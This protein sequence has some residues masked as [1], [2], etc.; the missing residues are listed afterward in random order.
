MNLGNFRTEIAAKLS[1]NVD[2]VDELAL[3]DGWVNDGVCYIV[4]EG[5]TRVTS[6]TAALEADEGDYE[7][8]TN[9]LRILWIQAASNGEGDELEQVGPTEIHRRRLATATTTSASYLYAV[10][11]ANLLML[12]PIPAAA[13]VLTIYY[14]PRPASLSAAIDTPT[15]IPAEF[16]YLVTLYALL[17]AGD[18]DDDQSSAQGER[19]Q[20]KLD[21]GV[22]RMRSRINRK[23]G[24]RLARAT[25]SRRGRVPQRNDLDLF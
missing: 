13:D 17:N 16:H 4:G 24:R 15:E 8:D 11:G 9:I 6:A 23:R 3:I 14:V 2:D 18:Y 1:L 7:L 20:Q 22:K 5:Q 12:Y 25:V 10:D 19:Y 21:A